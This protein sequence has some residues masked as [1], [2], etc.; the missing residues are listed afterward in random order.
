MENKLELD[1]YTVSDIKIKL[2][3]GMRQA[4]ELVNSGKFPAKRL[5]RKILIP[6][7][8]FDEWLYS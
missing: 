4:Y 6:R 2:N 1:V 5:G 3:I 7:K 8:T